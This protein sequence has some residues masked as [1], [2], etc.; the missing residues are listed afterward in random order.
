[1]SYLIFLACYAAAALMGWHWRGYVERRR[2]DRGR[3]AVLRIAQNYHEA[4]SEMS[5][6]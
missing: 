1:M 2:R 4:R 5:N 6:N 3:V